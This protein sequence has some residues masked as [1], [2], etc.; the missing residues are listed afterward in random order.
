METTL[1]LV[2]AKS[3]NNVSTTE[4]IGIALMSLY[5]NISNKQQ[6]PFYSIARPSFLP[7]ICL[8]V[9]MSVRPSVRPLTDMLAEPGSK[10]ISISHLSAL[11]CRC[12]CNLCAP[13]FVVSNS[14]LF[15]CCCCPDSCFLLF[16][17]S[18]N[19]NLRIILPELI[20]W[21]G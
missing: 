6:S 16:L 20:R 4:D 3:K 10:P 9:C 8:S 14:I 21:A 1:R 13:F 17:F 5:N 2:V 11:F 12:C 7:S 15:G 18:V 19:G